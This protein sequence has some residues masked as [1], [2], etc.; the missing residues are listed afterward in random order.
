MY[1]TARRYPVPRGD[2][3]L[4]AFLWAIR[5]RDGFRLKLLATG[6]FGLGVVIKSGVLTM[7]VWGGAGIALGLVIGYPLFRRSGRVP[8]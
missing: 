6:A 7:L 3:T 5:T 1:D 4:R 8:G 2:R